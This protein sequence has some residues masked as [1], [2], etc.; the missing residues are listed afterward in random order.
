M[1]NCN[2]CLWYFE[3]DSD[4]SSECVCEDEEVHYSNTRESSDCIGWLDKNHEADL[5]DVYMYCS[6]GLTKLSL[7]DLRKVSE[8]ISELL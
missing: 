3:G 7:D 6:I 8:L 5:R 1:R 2:N 4:L